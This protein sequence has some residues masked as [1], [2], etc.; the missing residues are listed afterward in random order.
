[1]E[2]DKKG[3][4]RESASIV[5]VGVMASAVPKVPRY[6]SLKRERR[7]PGGDR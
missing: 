1:M 3:G 2:G 5:C 7:I 6:A 4:E